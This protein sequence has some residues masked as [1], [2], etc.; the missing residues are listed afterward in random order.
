M[1]LS[2]PRLALLHWAT[3]TGAWIVEDDYYG[4]FRFTG[5]PLPALRLWMRVGA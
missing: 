1:M 2:L 4:E 5:P 3:R